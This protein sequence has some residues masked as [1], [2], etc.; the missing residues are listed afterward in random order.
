[1][2]LIFKNNVDVLIP[3]S[4]AKPTIRAENIDLN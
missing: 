1:M 2:D 4:I 3:I